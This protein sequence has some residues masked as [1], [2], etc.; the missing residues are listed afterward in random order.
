M[1]L[2][3]QIDPKYLDVN[4]LKKVTIEDLIGR[5]HKLRKSRN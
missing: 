1:F 5:G 3:I 4:K 2:K